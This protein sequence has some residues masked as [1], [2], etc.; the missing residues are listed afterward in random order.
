MRFPWTTRTSPKYLFFCIPNYNFFDITF[1]SQHPDLCG[2]VSSQQIFKKNQEESCVL[3]YDFSLCDPRTGG[4]TVHYQQHLLQ[5][6]WVSTLL[7]THYMVDQVGWDRDVMEEWMNEG[8]N[9]IIQNSTTIWYIIYG[10]QEQSDI[11]Y[12]GWWMK[13]GPKC[14]L[15]LRRVDHPN[16]FAD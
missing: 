8:T 4:T 11:L 16:G 9:K 6:R 12:M 2:K 13:Q 5:V 3:R 10:V 1:P 14:G 7:L 15:S